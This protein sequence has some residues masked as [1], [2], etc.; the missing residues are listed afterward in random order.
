MGH[1]WVQYLSD[2]TSDLGKEVVKVKMKRIGRN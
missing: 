1:V 2:C